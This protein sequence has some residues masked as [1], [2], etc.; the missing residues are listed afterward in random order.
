MQQISTDKATTDLVGLQQLATGN[1]QL[2]NTNNESL[3][4]FFASL[5]KFFGER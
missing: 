5:L 3:T 1:L 4:D 2:C